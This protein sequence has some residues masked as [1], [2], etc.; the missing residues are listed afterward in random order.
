M[1]GRGSPLKS[2]QILDYLSGEDQPGHRRYKGIASRHLTPLGAFPGPASYI[3]N[4]VQKLDI[5]KRITG[6]ENEKERD[7]MRDE[8][9]D[10][11][12]E[13]PKSVDNLLRIALIR[14]SAHRL[15]LTE[16]KGKN[17]RILFIFLPNANIDPVKIPGFLKEYGQEL[18]FTAYGVPSFTCKYR[19]TE[20]VETTAELILSKTEELLGK[21]QTLLRED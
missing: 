1:V 11:F 3:V 13:I 18:S 4:E 20:L 21:M 2:A 10:R 7:D 16:V 5:Y 9:L 19:K 12:G 15:D 14:V 8:L 6:I 17:E